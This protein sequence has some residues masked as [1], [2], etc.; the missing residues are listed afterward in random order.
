MEFEQF[1]LEYGPQ[2]HPLGRNHGFEG[3]LLETYQPDL[4]LVRA[5]AP[6]HIWTIC[7]YEDSLVIIP[8]FHLVNRFGYLITA[9]PW[10]DENL[11]VEID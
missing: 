1:I 10:T 8:G 11:Q 4:D 5:A 9:E 2:P 6:D 7:D 3:M